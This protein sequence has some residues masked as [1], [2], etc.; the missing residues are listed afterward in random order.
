MAAEPR[1]GTRIRRARERKRMSQ[2]GLA[3]AL[4]VSRSAVN[5][6]E[7]DRAYPQNSIGALEDVL[8]ISLTDGD[9]EAVPH[10]VASREQ[11]LDAVRRMEAEAR[12]VRAM[13]GSVATARFARSDVPVVVVNLP[14]AEAPSREPQASP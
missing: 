6:W 14:E 11:M 4:G 2:D 5:A 12:R 10:R 3:A 7:N 13:L 8:G 1:I 9:S